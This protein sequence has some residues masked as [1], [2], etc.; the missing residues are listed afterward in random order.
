MTAQTSATAENCSDHIGNN[1][2]NSN[3]GSNISK[4][5]I[6]TAGVLVAVGQAILPFRTP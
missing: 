6:A 2:I 1:R 4:G 3:T 5:V